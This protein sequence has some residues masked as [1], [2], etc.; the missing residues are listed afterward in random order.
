MTAA[1]SYTRFELLR[2]FRN[3]RFFFFS[4]AFPLVHLA[5]NM[6]W[7]TA[8]LVW[9]GRRLLGRPVKPEHSMTAR[10]VAVTT[11][12]GRRRR[13]LPDSRESPAA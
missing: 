2:A 13:G 8:V 7:V 10:S 9:T 1:L 12:T 3:R 4:L 6:A 5:R 11:R